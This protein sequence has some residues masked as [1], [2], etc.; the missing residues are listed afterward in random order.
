M[1]VPLVQL[2]TLNCPA[3][4]VNLIATTPLTTLQPKTKSLQS[5]QL[6]MD[7]AGPAVVVNLKTSSL[8]LG[9]LN[10]ANPPYI[11]TPPNF[12]KPDCMH[13]IAKIINSPA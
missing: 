2:E 1:D 12:R 4:S 11:C 8:L 13:Y 5:H 7:S 3:V 10:P 9:F 6:P